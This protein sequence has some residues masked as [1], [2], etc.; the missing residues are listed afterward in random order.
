M[1]TEND[2]RM[3]EQV[4]S[5]DELAASLEPGTRI[6]AKLLKEA[7]VEAAAGWSKRAPGSTHT[8]QYRDHSKSFR[9]K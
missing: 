5:K 8:K 6:V 3:F 1:V 2:V 9:S 7:E 4:S